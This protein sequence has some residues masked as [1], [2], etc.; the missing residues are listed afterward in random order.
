M[1]YQMIWTACEATKK[2]AWGRV[3]GEGESILKLWDGCGPRPCGAAHD[4]GFV[5]RDTRT[6]KEMTEQEYHALVNR[7]KGWNS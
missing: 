6:G 5:V 2:S 3:A 7:L 1:R 4:Q